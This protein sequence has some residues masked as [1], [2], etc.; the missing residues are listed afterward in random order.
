MP[1]F[2]ISF[3]IMQVYRKMMY[4][5][6]NF[7]NHS[8]FHNF[9]AE[10][11]SKYI[12]KNDFCTQNVVKNA[13]LNKF[14]ISLRNLSKSLNFCRKTQKNAIF[15]NDFQKSIRALNQELWVFYVFAKFQI[16]NHTGLMDAWMTLIVFFSF[17]T[18]K[19]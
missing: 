13:Y 1:C 10:D 19:E 14:P 12:Q 4:C 11:R 3:M 8:K 16:G 15:K 6:L 2:A 9:L 18:E 7:Q 5:S 17:K